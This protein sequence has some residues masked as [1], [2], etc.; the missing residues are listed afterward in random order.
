MGMNKAT[1]ALLKVYRQ[2]K[3]DGLNNK[4]IAQAMAEAGYKKRDG[5]PV[6]SNTIQHL[7][8]ISYQMKRPYTKKSSSKE[9]TSLVRTDQK[10]LTVLILASDVT[11][12]AKV[13]ALKAIYA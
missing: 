6:N 4:Q 8:K 12:S 7:S 11:D 13:H 5:E 10:E 9:T 3:V 2:Y 1:K